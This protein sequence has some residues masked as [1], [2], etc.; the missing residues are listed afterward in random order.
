MWTFLSE[1]SLQSQTIFP[2]LDTLRS[3]DSSAY[4]DVVPNNGYNHIALFDP[5]ESSTPRFLTSGPWEVTGGIRTVDTER[6][7]M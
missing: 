7:L 1:T 4:L 3:G 5:A 2:L 6:G